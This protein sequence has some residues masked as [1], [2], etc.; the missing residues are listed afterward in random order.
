MK[1]KKI[2]GQQLEPR[3]TTYYIIQHITHGLLHDVKWGKTGWRT[4]QN[5]LILVNILR[6]NRIKAEKWVFTRLDRLAKAKQ[7]KIKQ[8]HDFVET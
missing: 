1:L 8:Y 6:I 3:L 7:R 4:R 2:L 5:L